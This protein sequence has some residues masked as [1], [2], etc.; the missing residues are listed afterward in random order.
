[1]EA[2]SFSELLPCPFCGQDVK[3]QD[4]LDTLYPS[5]IYWRDDDEHGRHYVCR[6]I[7]PDNPCYQL[8]CHGCDAS[9]SGDSMDETA[10]KWNTRTPRL[11]KSEEVAP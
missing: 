8:V 6:S 11:Q 4:F 10:I 7:S 1:V 5:G 2:L 3:E 9:V